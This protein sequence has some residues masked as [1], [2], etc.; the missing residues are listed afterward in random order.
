[1]KLVLQLT[2]TESGNESFPRGA[3]EL[4]WWVIIAELV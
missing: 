2:I 4:G 3:G 1:M